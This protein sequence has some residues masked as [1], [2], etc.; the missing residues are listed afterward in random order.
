[1]H[2]IR[3]LAFS[4]LALVVLIALSGQAFSS[5]VAVGG[6]TNLVHFAT[7]QLAVNSVPAGSTIKVCPGTYREQVLITKN[8]TLIGTGPTAA[9]VL[10]PVGGLVKNGTD[11]ADFP[12]SDVAAQILVQGA[13][14]ATISHLIVDGTGNGLDG[15]GGVNMLG[16][17]YENSSGTITDNVVR[18][19]ITDT[20]VGCG[21]G[22][23]IY[24]A[25]NTDTPAV[26]ISNNSV[27]NYGKNGIIATGVGN[28]IPGPN[29]TLTGNTVVGIGATTQIAQNGIQLSLLAT[30]KIT[31]N[32]VVD[33]VYINP[34]CGSVGEPTCW[35]SSGILLYASNGVSVTSNIVESTQL[36]IVPVTDLNYGTGD[37]T[38]IKSNHIGGTQ[39]YDAID[40][41]SNGNTVQS[42]VIYGSAQ[43]GVHADDSCGGTG[44]NNVIISN[45]INEACTGILTG[46]GTS[47][48]SLTSN[49]FLNV[50]N[51]TLAG[52]VCTPAAGPTADAMG[53]S[54]SHPK[55]HSLRPS[56]RKN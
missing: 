21:L 22:F 10:P 11:L 14:K 41:C 56:A 49:T 6:C 17:Y 24:V 30:G 16:I 7:L 53:T 46:T 47:G 50:A 9:V 32:Y 13:A 52:D 25:S 5:T 37:G 38:I 51:T 12:V 20:N 42:N 55:S 8:L 19:Q 44:N 40:L 45:T 54:G 18:N 48:N 27:R 43:D 36:G 34:P 28:R 26:T 39:N 15:C 35:G 1:M 23:A 33:D 31:S 3:N 2:P 29:V 4:C